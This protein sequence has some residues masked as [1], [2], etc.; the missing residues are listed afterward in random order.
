MASLDGR[1]TMTFAS[2]RLIPQTFC[3]IGTVGMQK[4]CGNAPTTG[5][6]KP[7]PRPWSAD[8]GVNREQHL[9]AVNRYH[10]FVAS[11]WAQ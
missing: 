8:H 9:A 11:A 2:L 4:A 10:Y 5:L 6:R 1:G 7:G 3:C